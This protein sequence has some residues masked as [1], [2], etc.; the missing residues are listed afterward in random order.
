MER[1]GLMEKIKALEDALEWEHNKNQLN[2]SKNELKRSESGNIFSTS[3]A[4]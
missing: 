1:D 4:N 3:S 2:K